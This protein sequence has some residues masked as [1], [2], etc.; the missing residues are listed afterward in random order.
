[1]SGRQKEHEALRALREK[2]VAGEISGRE[3]LREVKGKLWEELEAGEIGREEYIEKM[4]EEMR[5]MKENRE[6]GREDFDEIEKLEKKWRSEAI[7]EMVEGDEEVRKLRE[8]RDGGELGERE[9]HEAELRKLRALW[10][11]GAI[12]GN[13]YINEAFR[14]LDEMKK[15]GEISAEEWSEE[16]IK[17]LDEKTEA[18]KK[19]PKKGMSINEFFDRAF[20]RDNESYEEEERQRRQRKGFG[21]LMTVVEVAILIAGLVAAIVYSW[22]LTVRIMGEGAEGIW[23]KVV[24]VMV[25]V[26]IMAVA[27]LLKRGAE[28][29]EE[30]IKRRVWA[31]LYDREEEARW[32][33]MRG[34]WRIR[35]RRLKR[36][37]ERGEYVRKWEEKCGWS[38]VEI[39][40]GAWAYE[41]GKG[42]YLSDGEV[43]TAAEDFNDGTAIVRGWG[44]YSA[45]RRPVDA[46]WENIIDT[47]GKKLLSTVG[48]G[49]LTRL[50]YEGEDE[51]RAGRWIYKYELHQVSCFPD[52]MRY[53]FIVRRD[54]THIWDF[55]VVIREVTGEYIKVGK[56][57][58][59]LP[60]NREEADFS[61]WEYYFKSGERRYN[62][63]IRRFERVNGKKGKI[64][65]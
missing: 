1:M 49:K 26:A 41:N 5:V 55:A 43:F 11:D 42:E 8:K 54:G 21:R 2:W 63:D 40:E 59:G 13:D 23:G 30:F 25:F 32:R 48:W 33:D 28:E 24:V 18:E 52:K 22:T 9:Y 62:E 27:L 15:A 65:G 53:V 58:E 7:W 50:E 64:L 31:D 17:T 51:E 14:K 34:G 44:S 36:K 3:Y 47:T 61:T 37:M 29:L 38:R 46:E 4:G 60:R 10:D 39:E 16:T 12:G 45:P 20:K 6:I 19:A 57:R 35:E 56:K